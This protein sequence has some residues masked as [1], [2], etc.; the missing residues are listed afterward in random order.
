ME[1]SNSPCPKCCGS[2]CFVKRL[3]TELL[4]PRHFICGLCQGDRDVPDFVA[5]WYDSNKLVNWLNCIVCHRCQGKQG[6]PCLSC[7]GSRHVIV[8][9]WGKPQWQTRMLIFGVDDP[10]SQK[11][12]IPPPPHFPSGK[13]MLLVRPTYEEYIQLLGGIKDNVG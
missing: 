13:P 2:G 10:M 11:K 4:L 8:D 12:Y 9:R 7:N 3:P 5:Y 1:M 6:T